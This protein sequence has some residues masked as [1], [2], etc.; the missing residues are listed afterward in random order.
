LV[1]RIQRKHVGF[2]QDESK[3]I[4][5]L[6]AWGGEHIKGLHVCALV[7]EHNKRLD[8]DRLKRLHQKYWSLLEEQFN[9][10]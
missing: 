1:Y 10:I 7:V 4:W 8:E 3:H 6:V 5:L 2:A 9:A